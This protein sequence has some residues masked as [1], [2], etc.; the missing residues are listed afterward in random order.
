[1]FIKEAHYQKELRKTIEAMRRRAGT[2]A[3]PGT[4]TLPASPDSAAVPGD[5]KTPEATDEKAK[6]H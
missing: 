4:E 5:R 2:P 6:A 1:V 3:P